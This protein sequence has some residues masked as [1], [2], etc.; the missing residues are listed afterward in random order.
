MRFEINITTGERVEFPDAEV[1]REPPAKLKRAELLALYD[2]YQA[3][4]TAVSQAWLSALIADG[5][6]EIER[7]AQL[8]A[9]IASIDEQ[10]ALGVV[11]I[12]AKY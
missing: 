12:R 6:M 3:D 1:V 10:Y 5:E 9:E 7:K 2:T 11:A 4:L 8:A